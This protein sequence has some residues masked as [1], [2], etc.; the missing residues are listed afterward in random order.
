MP[1]R[2]VL[3]A[4]VLGLLSA[5]GGNTATAPGPNTAA[6]T[7]ANASSGNTESPANK[8]PDPPRNK[9]IEPE[10]APVSQR[11]AAYVSFEGGLRAWPAEKRVE[12]DALMLSEQTRPLEFLLVAPGGATHESLFA[13]TAKGEHLKRALEIVG[14]A[15]G[16][17]KRMGRGYLEKPTGDRVKISVRFKHADTGETTVVRVEE[18]LMDFR[19]EG[20]PEMV[21]WVFTGSQEQFRPE[22]NRSLFEA[23]LKGNLIAMW[24]DASCVL[25][26]DRE[27]GTH[28]DVYSP[29]PNAPGIPRA[30]RGQPAQV[31]LIFEPHE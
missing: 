14:L 23:D 9:P 16:K 17:E 2:L 1:A 22:L 6:G 8:Q 27:S 3:I 29:N 4:L 12:M 21:G 25:D 13:A 18:W 5:C 24:R 26:N 30:E 15:E 28:S 19:L 20:K 31:T 7:P 11:E 10:P